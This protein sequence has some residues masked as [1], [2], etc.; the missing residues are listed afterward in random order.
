MKTFKISSWAEGC[1]SL[2]TAIL[3]NQT[4]GVRFEVF[5]VV[6]MKNGIFWDIKTQFVPH[7]R[8]ITS[9]LLLCYCY[10]RFEVFIAVTVK[11]GIFWNVTP[12]GSC[13]N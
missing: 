4:G 11:N 6:T 3:P 5:M 7:R 8:H 1:T 13:K 2:N 10:V 12:C 9:P